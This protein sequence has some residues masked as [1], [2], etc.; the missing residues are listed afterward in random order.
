MLRTLRTSRKGI[1]TIIT[2]K[3]LVERFRKREFLEESKRKL[4]K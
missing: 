2:K 1:L 4:S 3:E